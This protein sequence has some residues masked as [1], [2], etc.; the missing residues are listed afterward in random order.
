MS[1]L[2]SMVAVLMMALVL[3][4]CGGAAPAGTTTTGDTPEAVAKAF[5]EATFSGNIEAARGVVCAAMAAELT[6]EAASAMAAMG[7]AEMDFSGLTF[8]PSDVTDTSATVTVGGKLKVTVAGAS[9]ELDFATMGSSA[10]FPLVKENGAWKVC[11][12]A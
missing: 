3:A 4:A 7:E 8:T 2:M 11:Q 6:D 5:V 12:A 1:K 10:A 9:Q